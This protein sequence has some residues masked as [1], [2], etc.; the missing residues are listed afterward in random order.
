LKLSFDKIFDAF[1]ETCFGDPFTVS[2]YIN[3]E[4]GDSFLVLDD[5][6]GYN[7]ENPD[8][9]FENDIYFSLPDP[10]ELTSGRDLAFKFASAEVR[11]YSDKIYEIFQNRGAFSR[12]KSLLEDI[13]KIDDWYKFEQETQKAE[14]REWCQ[15][16]EIDLDDEK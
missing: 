12:F 3:K 9:L 4:N 14:L 1:E 8:D 5:D 6:D 13:G 2:V 15:L 10:S 11:E 7:E 16:N